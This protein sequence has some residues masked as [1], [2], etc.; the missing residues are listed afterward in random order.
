MQMQ[1]MACQLYRSVLVMKNTE[2]LFDKAYQLS[3]SSTAQNVISAVRES[4]TIAK[5]SQSV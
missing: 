3:M 1:S 4:S 2:M 5:L